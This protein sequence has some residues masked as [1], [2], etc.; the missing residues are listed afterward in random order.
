MAVARP[1]MTMGEGHAAK[2]GWDSPS[3]S[4]PPGTNSAAKLSRP[5]YQGLR[6]FD[7][8]DDLA[9]DV[10]WLTHATD[11]D[12]AAGEPAGVGADEAVAQALELRD[13]FLRDGVLP[14]AV[15]HRG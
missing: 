6:I 12:V 14:H 10:F 4:L 15:V 8:F 2:A 11:A 1:S 5:A 13:V 3:L 9:Y 7:E